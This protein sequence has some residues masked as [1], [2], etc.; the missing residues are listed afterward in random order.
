[1]MKRFAC[2]NG[3]GLKSK[4]YA[5]PVT[6]ISNSS[7][8]EIKK[9]GTVV[10]ISNEFEKSTVKVDTVV[11]AKV[12]PNDSVYEGFLEAGLNAAKIGDAKKVR[13]VR[14]AV[15]DGANAALVIEEGAMLNA[16][17]GLISN[18]PSGIDLP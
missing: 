2:G 6:V 16:N 5:H 1:M 10:I 9:D 7:V 8:Q 17:N 11:L 3:E 15:T 12:E 4:T 14:G 13:N 18:L